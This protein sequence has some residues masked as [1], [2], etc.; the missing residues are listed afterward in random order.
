M[1]YI[2]SYWTSSIWS[3]WHIFRGNLQ[4]QL[5][6]LFLINSKRSFIYT[7][8]KTGQHLPQPLMWTHW[9]ERDIILTA[10]EPAMQTRSYDPNLYRWVLYHLSY[11]PPHSKTWP[12]APW[13][14]IDLPPENPALYHFGEAIW[15]P[16]FSNCNHD[17]CRV[18][19]ESLRFNKPIQR[20]Y[21]GTKKK[22]ILS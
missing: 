20:R 15:V 2:I 17:S 9:L 21:K 5:R 8:P 10:N 1:I 13:Y 3:L 7:F 11:V 6:L 16:W 19:L 18:V 4:S 14:N 12:P 22:E